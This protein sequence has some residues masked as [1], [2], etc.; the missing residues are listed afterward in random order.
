MIH[1]LIQ[2][3]KTKLQGFLG[4]SKLEDELKNYKISNNGRVSS[5]ET[6]F[7][8]HARILSKQ[9][10]KI[11]ALHDTLSNVVSLGSDIS[12]SGY[13]SSSW[14]V[15]CIEGK[16]NVVKFLDLN[17]KSGNEVLRI[18]KSFEGSRHVNDTPM[19]YFPKEMFIDWKS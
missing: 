4:V 12:P 2:K 6:E 8:Y 5:I 7:L 10:N 9:D 16:T 1:K 3:V 13:R 18:L 14:A 17:H 11:S 15:V 19:G